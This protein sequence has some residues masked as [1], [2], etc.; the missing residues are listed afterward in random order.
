MPEMYS[1]QPRFNYSAWRLFIKN[2][3]QRQKFKE[4]DGWKY[5]Y[6]NEL[7]KACFQHEM[8]YGNFKDLCKRTITYKIK[9][10][11]TFNISKYYVY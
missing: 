2:K 7:G 8:A 5:I 1:K 11:K 10:D 3:E 6:Q 4:R 9:C